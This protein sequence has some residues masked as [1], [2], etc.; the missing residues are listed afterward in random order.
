LVYSIPIISSFANFTVKA[1]RVEKALKT[2]ASSNI[3]VSWARHI[4]IVAAVTGATRS[5]RNL[6]IAEVV[7]STHI[8][9]WS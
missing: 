4:D 9:P 8:T 5:T 1:L 6:G 7:V 3:T 2:F